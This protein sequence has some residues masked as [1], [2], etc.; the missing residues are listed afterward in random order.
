MPMV[1][2]AARNNSTGIVTNGTTN[3]AGAYQFPTLQPGAYTVTAT[4]NGF[5][6]ETYN[7]VALGQN[8]QVRLN[9]TMQVAAAGETVEVIAEADTALATTSSS[10]GGV[11]AN[12]DVQELPVLSRNALDLVSLTPGVV[13][14]QGVFTAQGTM[15]SNFMGA[16]T[17]DV[18]TTRDGMVSSDGRYNSSN[19]AY[20]AT[21]TSPDMVEEVR[22]ST[23]TIDPTLG[24][25]N[26]QVQMRTRA[27]GNDF[28]GALFYT[29]A[30]SALES[31][32]YFANLQGQKISYEN[33]NQYGGRIGGPIKKNKAFF[34]FLID[35]E[36]YQTKVNTVSEVLTG[37]ARQGIFRYLTAGSPG[38]TSRK[39]GNAFST[40]PSVDL[41]GN[42]LTSANG[43]PLYLNQINM[44]TQVGDPNRSQIDPVWVGPQYLSRMPLPNNYTV[45][46]GL[47]TAGYQWQQ[48]QTGVDGATGQSPD[49]NRN[50]YTLRLDYQVNDKN[51]LSFIMTREHDYGVTSQ[52][53]LPGYP[54]M[55]PGNNAGP[56]FFGD[57]QR[58][59]NFYTGSWVATITPSLLNEFR[60]GYKVDTWQGTSPVDLGCCFQ[61]ASNTSLSPSAKQA[62]DTF[63]MINGANTV[64]QPDTSTAPINPTG[65]GLA[66][67]ATINVSAPRQTISPYLQ[68]AD[69][70]SWNH[71]AHAFQG[72]FDI[73]R[74]SS[75][76]ANAGNAQ[77]TRPLVQLGVG[78]VQIPN[79]NTT[80]FAGLN[81]L[82]VT[83]AQEI[84]SN[85]AGTVSS[86]TQQYWVN[87]PSATNWN[88][89]QNGIFILRDNHDNQW[90]GFF[91]DNWKVTK[92]FTVNLGLRYDW[93][94]TP[95]MSQGLGGKFVNLFGLS[96]TNFATAATNRYTTGGSLTTT[97]FTGPNSPNPNATVY[98]N[99]DTSF[100]PSAGISWQLPWFKRSTVFRA[101]YGLNYLTPLADYLSINTN[102]GGLPGQTL[103]TTA[104][105]NNYVS[106]ATLNAT[107]LIPVTTQGTQ[108]FQPVPVTNRTAPAAGYAPNLKNP[109]IQVYNATIQREI[110]HTLTFDA[111]YIGNKSTKL[112]TTQ[113]INDVDIVDNGFLDAFNVVRAG[114]D[115]PLFNAMLNGYNIPGVGVVGQTVSGS[116][117]LRRYTSTNQ[118]LANGQVGALA[119]FINTTAALSGVPG[120]I[121]RN[122]HLPENFL[123]VNPQFGSVGLVGNNG[124]ETYNAGQVH[125]AQRFTHG[126]SGQFAYTFSKALGDAGSMAR[127][128]NDYALN[129]SLL[130]SDRTHV[131][132]QNF[133]Y[134]LPFG[135][136]GTYLT[137]V[138]AWADEAIGGWQISSGMSWQSGAPL[139]FT[140][141]N[142]L[143]QYGS[144]TAQLVGALPANYEQVVKG[145]GYVTYFPTLS[146]QNAPVPNFGTGSDAATLAGRYTNLQV[147]GPNGPV[148]ANAQPGFTGD[149]ANNMPQLRGPGFLSFNGAAGK[150]FRI[151]EKW[152][153]TLR[154]DVINILNKPQWGTPTT[155][156][157]STSFGR[158]TT[159]FGSR[160]V[161]LNARVDF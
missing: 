70:V 55:T 66:T 69:T 110:T 156:I 78:N 129:K 128:Q 11:L 62:L 84:L 53:G 89:Y 45:G 39:N 123:V 73:S 131:I 59:P 51:K 108:P 74:T 145:N 8:Q 121:L 101:G 118:F 112:N 40:T 31:Q 116:Q 157:N 63:P 67:Y 5:K 152:T 107:G 134:Q 29:N 6:T 144:A 83:T 35:D 7:D 126:L 48:T 68:F 99:D 115:S 81:A 106:V 20:S 50:N 13:G 12:R 17:Q 32:N 56:G 46:D 130:S 26:A 80:N 127:M 52:T 111:S 140:A 147:I 42:I 64:V 4:L 41:N 117:A 96:G 91:K 120:G 92:N 159:A 54:A 9:F 61:G 125:L 146:V 16:R 105:L 103:N 114:G 24:R 3:T 72:G 49:P 133:T 21:F 86:I 90:S 22:V 149:T 143:N 34:F 155:N 160:T 154:A 14:I 76:A 44:F 135:K 19:G 136:S 71:G 27:G 57:V 148:L 77:T 60:M 124:N 47:N 38:G 119:N 37:P 97:E 122:A 139:S 161:T 142:T 28:H 138:P 2:V 95:Y 36:R 93:Y 132:Q 23:N 98:N 43:Q 10:V 33:R 100:G 94:G 102:I 153:A 141:N 82:D 15:I 113:Q 88:N 58:Y 87:S 30:N 104:P 137:H 1:A 150:V 79:L 158:I 151:R 109:Y 65:L 18:N 75:A 25:G 85:L